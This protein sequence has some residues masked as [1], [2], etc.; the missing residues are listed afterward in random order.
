MNPEALRPVPKRLI[1]HPETLGMVC[2]NLANRLTNNQWILDATRGT[3]FTRSLSEQIGFEAFIGDNEVQPTLNDIYA[4]FYASKQTIE[5]Y[6][7]N[8]ADI[9]M[10]KLTMSISQSIDQSEVPQQVLDEIFES[11]RDVEDEDEFESVLDVVERDN[12]DEF[13]ITREQVISY[14]ITGCG[15]I[16]TYELGYT[17]SIEDEEVHEINYSS[18]YGT[19]ITA[20][21]TIAKTGEEVDRRPAVLLYLTDAQLELEV[22]EMDESWFQFIQERT[23]TEI[24]SFGAQDQAQ[25]RH[26]A[27]AMISLLSSGLFTLRDLAS[28]K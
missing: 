27:L 14:D 11:K 4:A 10:Y 5:G 3:D 20:P 9:D 13:D 6:R 24:A 19:R 21:I 17:Y 16:E 12:L 28:H 23:L 18:E 22:N 15:D 2:W 25:H 26:Q 8:A 7:G 1:T